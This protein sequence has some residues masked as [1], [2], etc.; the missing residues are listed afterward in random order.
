MG[1]GLLEGVEGGERD[2][3]EPCAQGKRKSREERC[4]ECD[5]VSVV[6]DMTLTSMRVC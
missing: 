4:E 1:H 5:G 6:H 3:F 2:P